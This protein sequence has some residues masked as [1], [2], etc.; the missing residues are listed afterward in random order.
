MEIEISQLLLSAIPSY[1]IYAPV[2]DGMW[3]YYTTE[4]SYSFSN[5]LL[6]MLQV[7]NHD[8]CC[9]SKNLCA[10]CCTGAD[11]QIE[12]LCITYISNSFIYTNKIAKME[13]KFVIPYN[14]CACLLPGH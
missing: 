6:N 9:I 10:T 1:I 4:F 3:S 7:H 12:I 8:D 5:S 13:L 14:L 2:K 11:K